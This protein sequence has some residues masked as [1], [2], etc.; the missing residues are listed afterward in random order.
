MNINE[1]KDSYLRLLFLAFFALFAFVP[2]SSIAETPSNDS[3][4]TL[5][6][7]EH[8]EE[9]KRILLKP[10]E[11]KAMPFVMK[12]EPGLGDV[13]CADTGGKC[14]FGGKTGSDRKQKEEAF[15]E[16]GNGDQE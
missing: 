14:D 2:S 5:P 10:G 16:K 15:G 7:I 1:F 9:E 8:A 11:V 4:A 13:Y 6:N 12:R 3:V